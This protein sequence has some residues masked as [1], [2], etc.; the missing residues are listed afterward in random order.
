MP[1]CSPSH[2]ICCGWLILVCAHA[3]MPIY[4]K[5]WSGSEICEGEHS[6]MSKVAT[7]LLGHVTMWPR[8]RTHITWSLWSFGYC[9][10]FNGFSYGILILNSHLEDFYQFVYYAGPIVIANTHFELSFG[11]LLWDTCRYFYG[12]VSVIIPHMVYSYGILYYGSYIFNFY[13]YIIIIY[14]IL[15]YII[16]IYIY[17]IYIYCIY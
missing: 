1:T 15:L 3:D 6:K 4:S 12:S 7:W 9:S 11:I 17:N 10:S 5:I 14:Y 2:I 13:I 8:C 16:Y